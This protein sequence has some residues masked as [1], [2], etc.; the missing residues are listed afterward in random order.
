M[1]EKKTNIIFCQASSFTNVDFPK[2]TK[3]SV[4]TSCQFASDWSEKTPTHPHF[5]SYLEVIYLSLR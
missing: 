1:C 2:E 4:Y 3:M 5:I